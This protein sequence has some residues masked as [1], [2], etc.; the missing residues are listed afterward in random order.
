MGHFSDPALELEV[1]MQEQNSKAMILNPLSKTKPILG[2]SIN[3]RN[4]QSICVGRK[5]MHMKLKNSADP[6]CVAA[7]DTI[8]W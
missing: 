1:T 8:D 7:D 5:W 4:S 3:T 2:G 6:G